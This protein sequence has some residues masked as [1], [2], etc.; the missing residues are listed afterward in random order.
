MLAGGRRAFVKFAT[1]DDGIASNRVERIV[2][3]T[4]DS[5]HLPSLMGMSDDAAVLITEDLSAADWTPDVPVAEASF[6]PAAAAIGALQAPA[7]LP[8][9]FQGAGRD[10]WRNVLRDE[11]FPAAA[12]LPAS[13]L[14]AHGA[15]LSAVAMRADTSGDRLVH[16]DLAPGNWCR[17]DDGRWRF[18]DW[19]S[20]HRGNPL[21]DDAIAAIRL[22]RIGGAVRMS[23]RLQERPEIAVLVAGRFAAE[24]L[25]VDWTGAPE[26]ARDDRVGDIRAGIALS[27]NVL[28]IEVPAFTVR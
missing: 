1:D 10:P 9:S 2:L 16:G 4:I 26:V 17:D 3:G 28:G 19:A 21:V 23:K 24:L 6:W 15:T 20:A 25:D 22:T 27:A 12:G 11:R 7:E 18:V 5:P 8:A 13:W 14:E